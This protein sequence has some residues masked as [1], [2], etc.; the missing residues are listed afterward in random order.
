VVCAGQKTGH[1]PGGGRWKPGARVLIRKE[2]RVVD[3]HKKWGGTGE[4]E[5]VA[6]SVNWM[7]VAV[8]LGQR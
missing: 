4:E 7:Q 6:C 1:K 8:L 2:G 5:P 3:V